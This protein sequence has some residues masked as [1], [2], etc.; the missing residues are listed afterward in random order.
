MRE[1]DYHISS[2]DKPE[3]NRLWSSSLMCAPVCAPWPVQA[4]QQW[5]AAEAAGRAGLRGG[6]Q[7]ACSAQD[8]GPMHFQASRQ[9]RSA[10]VRRTWP[11]FL[12]FVLDA[13]S[14]DLEEAK[15]FG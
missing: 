8:A 12:A 15:L 4:P 3:C 1:L 7:A 10:S 5:G 14:K 9:G 13:A 2:R 11:K 6:R